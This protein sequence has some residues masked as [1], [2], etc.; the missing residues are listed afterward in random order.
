[1]YRTA[2]KLTG[3]TLVILFCLVSN[4][5]DAQVVISLYSNCPGSSCTMAIGAP[6]PEGP[7]GQNPLLPGPASGSTDFNPMGHPWT[8]S[9]E[10]GF[11]QTWTYSY[12]GYMYNANFGQGGVFQMTG[13]EGTF[14]GVIT[15]AS[16]QGAEV[17]F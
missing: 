5:L 4:R 13:P 17:S 10:T 11:P 3:F 8:F 16:A 7:P 12:D 6:V 14:T 2:L 1:M 9:F 15:S